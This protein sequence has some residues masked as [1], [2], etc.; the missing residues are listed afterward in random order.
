MIKYSYQILDKG[1]NK[2][3]FVSKA[4]A[5]SAE[6]MEQIALDIMEKNVHEQSAPAAPT[7]FKLPHKT[8]FITDIQNGPK[9]CTEKYGMPIDVILAESE[10]AFPDLN[11]RKYLVP[12]V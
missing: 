6:Q 8:I 10:K 7:S 4:K 11:I 1:P 9:F 12:N 3:F 2:Y 5:F